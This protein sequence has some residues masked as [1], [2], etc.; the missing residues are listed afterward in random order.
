MRFRLVLA[1]LIG[2]TSA[3]VVVSGAQSKPAASA[4]PVIVLDTEK[5]MIEFETFPQD[6]PKSV[7]HL[8]ALVRRGFY[9][10][11]RFH[12]VQPGV[13][14]IGDPL[15]RNMTKTAD[16]GNGDSGERV[17]VAEISK[18]PFVR[19]SVGLFYKQG[20]KPEDSDSQ[21]FILLADNPALNGKYIAIGRVTKGLDV[22]GK[23]QRADMLKL[24]YVKGEPPK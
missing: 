4:P 7:A 14:Q 23:I 19:G 3:G 9:R 22:A 8:L 11:L 5:G 20:R 12:W 10:G 24:A 17:G 21:F 2:M 15:T 1:L 6:A 16:W 13:I 18:R